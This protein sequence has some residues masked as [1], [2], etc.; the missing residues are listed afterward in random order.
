MKS[1]SAPPRVDY[2]DEIKACRAFLKSPELVRA[3]STGSFPA[4]ETH[5]HTC[6][7]DCTVYLHGNYAFCLSTGNLHHCTDQ[8]KLLVHSR[9]Q[10]VCPLTGIEQ[11]PADYC[12]TTQFFDN[13]SRK[14]G[15]HHDDQATLSGYRVDAFVQTLR[16]MATKIFEKFN[17]S[18]LRQRRNLVVKD[19]IRR[20]Q[21]A[22][23]KKY[24]GETKAPRT[25]RMIG[26]G[27]SAFKE[28]QRQGVATR[29]PV[30]SPQQVDDFANACIYYYFR[31]SELLG[32][33]K[34][35]YDYSFHCV[36]LMYALA[37]GIDKQLP[38]WPWLATVIPSENEVKQYGFPRRMVTKTTSRLIEMLSLTDPQQVFD[39]DAERRGFGRPWP[40]FRGRIPD[41][42]AKRRREFS[43]Y[44]KGEVEESGE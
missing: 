20:K 28:E 36:S 10:L 33:G 17:Q 6:T 9:G 8:C 3:A 1:A 5:L 27:M 18:E 19:G 4:V 37:Q 24:L 41:R 35:K 44:S 2:H 40:V 7:R 42:Q 30:I 11:K 34:N 32:E 43:G 23:V 39:P 15:T 26:V 16:R 31:F 14:R 38:A 12:E 25:V 22:N 21:E 29:L 13:V